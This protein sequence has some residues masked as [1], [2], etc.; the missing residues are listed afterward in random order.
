MQYDREVGA[1]G[2]R[3]DLEWLEVGSDI[4]SRGR[5]GG[6]HPGSSATSADLGD[7]VRL[8]RSV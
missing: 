8:L 1:V 6:L 4:R 7:V 2:E 3:V 5:R